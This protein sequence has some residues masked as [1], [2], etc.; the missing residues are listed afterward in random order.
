MLPEG[1]VF[2]PVVGVTAL[3]VGVT[4]VVGVVPACVVVVAEIAVLVACAEVTTEFI[5]VLSPWYMATETP[6]QASSTTAKTIPTISPT[7]L[8]RLGGGE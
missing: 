3:V 1:G 2:S 8:R 5:P 4:P 6:T 7:L